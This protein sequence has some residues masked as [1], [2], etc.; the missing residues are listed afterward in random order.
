M[1]LGRTGAR[2][3]EHA[4]DYQKENRESLMKTDLSVT[5]QKKENA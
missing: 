1:A 5:I 3:Q 2:N 4:A